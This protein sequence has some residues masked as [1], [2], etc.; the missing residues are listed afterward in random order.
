MKTNKNYPL[1]ASFGIVIGLSIIIVILLLK[2]VEKKEIDNNFLSEK[3]ENFKDKLGQNR[4]KITRTGVSD[5]RKSEVD[6]LRNALELAKKDK[7]FD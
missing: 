1:F 3:I 6:S 7:E 5:F 2:L 4:A